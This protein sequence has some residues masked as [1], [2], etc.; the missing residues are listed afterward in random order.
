MLQTSQAYGPP[1][2][3]L[4]NSSPRKHRSCTVRVNFMLNHTLN[5]S[6]KSYGRTMTMTPRYEQEYSRIQPASAPVCFAY[7]LLL[8]GDKHLYVS[9]VPY[10]NYAY[11][12]YCLID[13][14]MATIK[15][16]LSNLPHLPTTIAYLWNY[17]LQIILWCH[18]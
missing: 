4:W 11:I 18:D 9:I 12:N 10:G 6:T 3:T 16:N 14:C 5:I 7:K 13:R 15:Y 8:Q 1:T 17:L 2:I